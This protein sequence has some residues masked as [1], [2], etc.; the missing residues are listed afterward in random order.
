VS[1]ALRRRRRGK[2]GGEKG[3]TINLC[4]KSSLSQSS[5]LALT[6]PPER[7]RKREIGRGNSSI[8]RNGERRRARIA[9]ANVRK[10]DGKKNVG[11]LSLLSN[12]EERK[13]YNS[14]R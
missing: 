5:P 14:S 6:F 7:K 1:R 12:R 8:E 3:A 13:G 11:H 10:K 2:G 4:G 9:G